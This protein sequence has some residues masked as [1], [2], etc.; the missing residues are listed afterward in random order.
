MRQYRYDGLDIVEEGI[1][2]W[3]KNVIDENIVFS[4]RDGETCYYFDVK[5]LNRYDEIYHK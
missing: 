2:I 3:I 4:T 5:F 1:F